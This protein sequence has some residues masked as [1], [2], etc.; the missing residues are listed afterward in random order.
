MAKETSGYIFY[1]F[2]QIIIND[3]DLSP[4]WSALEAGDPSSLP[5]EGLKT[6]F[7]EL[8]TPLDPFN[9]SSLTWAEGLLHYDLT[10]P[11]YNL[12]A[13]VLRDPGLTVDNMESRGSQGAQR[14]V[15]LLNAFTGALTT[16]QPKPV[17]PDQAPRM[18]K[19]DPNGGDAYIIRCVYERP[20]CTGIEK[21]T[22][23]DPSLP[24]QIAPF[25]DV[26]APA[27]EVRIVMPAD[28]SIAALRKYKKNVSVI[29]SDQLRNQ[30][31]RIRGLK[32][33]DVEDG[34]IGEPGG[35]SFGMICTL[36]IPII[37]ICALILL[38][39]IIQILN[40]IF[41]WIPFVK[42]CF[43]INFTAKPQT[44]PSG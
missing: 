2:K 42:V 1:D 18:P 24:F 33:K 25:Y 43:P 34:N 29:V 8:T 22:V 23:S 13:P 20:C 31:E 3:S 5:T 14:L 4:L 35:F 26:E 41:W 40:I 10:N 28:T 17:P 32:L 15:A 11:T 39:I 38:I 9:T 16:Y 12:S 19:Y 30:L 21:Q 37:T 27:R 44:P 6:L 36:S 7:T